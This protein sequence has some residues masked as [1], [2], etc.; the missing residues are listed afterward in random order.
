[1]KPEGFTRMD[2]V[3]DQ[4]S[5]KT[6][7]DVHESRVIIIGNE[8]GGAGKSTVAMHLSVALMRMGKKVGANGP[9]PA[10]WRTGPAG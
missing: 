2:R 1:M 6:A 9:L 3:Q 5:E 8:K 10:I 7:V 4:P